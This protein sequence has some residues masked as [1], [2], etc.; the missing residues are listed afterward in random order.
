METNGT[1]KCPRTPVFLCKYV[2]N[3]TYFQIHANTS[4]LHCSTKCDPKQLVLFVQVWFLWDLK[5]TCTLADAHVCKPG[6]CLTASSVQPSTVTSDLKQLPSDP[7]DKTIRGEAVI[8]TSRQSSPGSPRTQGNQKLVWGLP[9]KKAM[10][11]HL[12]WFT[13][14]T[15]R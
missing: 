4:W 6:T 14:K 8:L 1:L 13:N 12:Q 10:R 7:H 11:M 2:P 9:R 5:L 15:C 3:R